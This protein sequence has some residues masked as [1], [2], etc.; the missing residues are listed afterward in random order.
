MLRGGAQH[1]ADLSQALRI[2]KSIFL[3]ALTCAVDCMQQI[4]VGCCLSLKYIIPA[5]H[6]GRYYGHAGIRLLPEPI[7]RANVFHKHVAGIIS[8]CFCCQQCVAYMKQPTTVLTA[9]FLL[10]SILLVLGG[11]G[12][13]PGV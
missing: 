12:E 9:R 13:V 3:L 8:S 4:P 7:Q 11:G 5:C 10:Q 6:F 1:A 2:S